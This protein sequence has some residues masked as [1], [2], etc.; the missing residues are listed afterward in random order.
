MATATVSQISAKVANRLIG[1][2]GSTIDLMQTLREE[3]RAAEAIVK[4]IEEQIAVQEEALYKL[5]DAQ[6]IKKAGGN[7]ATAS[8][9]SAV[10]ASVDDWDAFWAWIAKKKYFHLIQKRV[11]DP[12]YR[13]LLEKGVNVPGVQP[14]T[15]RKL[16]LTSLNA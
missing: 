4:G 3:K 11:S 12:G 16:T 2:L 8:I 14:F 5:M 10:V 7:K 9:G 6:G 1:S 15:K 13:E